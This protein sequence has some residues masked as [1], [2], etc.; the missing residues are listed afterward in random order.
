MCNKSTM[1]HNVFIMS[2]KIVCMP[3]SFGQKLKEF[4]RCSTLPKYRRNVDD[5]I[6]KYTNVMAK[7]EVWNKFELC[8]LDK[9][10]R[11]PLFLF[12]HSVFIFSIILVHRRLL[13]PRPLGRGPIEARCC[14]LQYSS[15]VSTPRPLGRGPITIFCALFYFSQNCFAVFLICG[16]STNVPDIESVG[17]GVL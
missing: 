8:I 14:M 3:D 9:L 5:C 6:V 16:G 11:Q 15:I 7:K 12:L 4:Y 17:E 10:T 1:N 13:F 2:A